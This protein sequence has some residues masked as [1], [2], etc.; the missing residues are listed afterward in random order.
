MC[1]LKNWPLSFSG[2]TA[3]QRLKATRAPQHARRTASGPT[4]SLSAGVRCQAYSYHSNNVGNMPVSLLMGVLGR[5]R[6]DDRDHGDK[7][8]M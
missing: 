1:K 6:F 2:V 3:R 7:P 5:L 4:L 8:L